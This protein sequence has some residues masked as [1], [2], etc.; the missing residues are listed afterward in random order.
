MKRLAFDLTKISFLKCRNKSL[1]IVEVLNNQNLFTESNLANWF[2][3]YVQF[4]S[5]GNFSERAAAARL[6]GKMNYLKASDYF[7][8]IVVIFSIFYTSL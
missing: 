7:G 5:D 1:L 6:S 2:S 4:C 8:H 3:S